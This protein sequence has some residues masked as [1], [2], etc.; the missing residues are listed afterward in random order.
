[1]MRDGGPGDGGGDRNPGLETEAQGWI[2][3]P[4]E[5]VEKERG[6]AT[7]SKM[8]RS[9]LRNPGIAWEGVASPKPRGKSCEA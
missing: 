7:C 2:R 9:V 1:M 6:P 3:L 5:R 4:R 8:K